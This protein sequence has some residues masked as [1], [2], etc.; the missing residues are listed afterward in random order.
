[1][2]T[3]NKKDR[4]D[5]IVRYYGWNTLF[6]SIAVSAETGS[7]KDHQKIFEKVLGGT[8]V[9]AEECVFIDNQEKNLIVPKGMGMSVVYFDHQKRDYDGLISELRKLLIKI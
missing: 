3:D 4:V 5:S 2:V 9:R 7:G 8:G 6:N 1:M